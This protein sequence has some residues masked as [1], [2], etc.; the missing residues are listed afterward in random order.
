MNKTIKRVVILLLIFITV[1]LLYFVLNRNPMQQSNPMYRSMEAP[2]LPVVHAQM[3]GREMNV[4]YGYRQEMGNAA[5]RESLT[6]LPQDRALQIRISQSDQPVAALRYEIR[7]L[8]LERL[9]ENTTVSGWQQQ[10]DVVVATLPIQNLLTSDREYLLRIEVDTETYGTAYY[11][12]RIVWTD[13][14]AIQPMID[15]AVDFSRRTFNYEEARELTTYLETNDTEDNSSFGQTTIRSS[16]SH[17]T[18]GRLN[19]EPAGD[20][21]V[22]LKEADGLMGIVQL[23]YLASRQA[24]DGTAELYEVEESFTMRW[25][26]LRIYMMDYQRKADQVFL[27][28]RT[29]YS[30][31]RIMLGITNDQEVSVKKSDNNQMLAF[32]VNRE[33]WRYD[34]TEQ[35]AVQIFSFRSENSAD[36]RSNH[37]DH[38]IN[39]LQVQDNGDVDFLVYG[40]MNRGRHEGDTG[41]AG[42]HYDA[43]D[44]AIVERFFIPVQATYDAIKGDMEQ[45]AGINSSDMLYLYLNQAVYGIDLTSN[46]YMVVA[47][48]LAEGSFAVSADRSRI[49]WQE[50][51]N[52]YDAE[53]LH[54]LDLETGENKIIQAQQ[55]DRVRVIG[56]VGN[57]LVY[58]LAKASDLWVLNGRTVELP[59]YALEIMNTGMGVET[60]YENAGS[61]I[62]DV[63]V[64]ESRIHLTRMVRLDDSQYTA[65]DQDTIV[66]NV[67]MGPDALAGIGWYAS[68]D[69]GK[70]YFVQVDTD[71][72]SNGDVSISA[73]RRISYDS[74]ARLE[75]N[76]RNQV[77]GVQF[78]AYGGG[79]MLG[80]SGDL[81]KVLD[82]AYDSMGV[83]IDQNHNMIWGR[84][85]RGDSR[86]IRDTAVAA[87]PLYRH[88]DEFTGS[89]SYSDGIILIDARGCTMMQVLYFI[90]KG[91]PVVAY[92]GDGSHLLLTGFDQYNVS[93]YDPGTGET[94]RVGLNDATEFFRLRGNDFVCAIS[95]QN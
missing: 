60:R 71:I 88:L 58:G 51:A 26:S 81:K 21:Q 20:V 17:L 67:G 46:E 24:E 38:D 90:D 3:Y 28:D 32:M 2:Q 61:Y 1:V 86:N 27:G 5:A 63:S 25:N 89:E 40:Y 14:A 76:G 47:D 64:E 54:L 18:W 84:I 49:A 22:T 35:D 12:T 9:V 55:E 57:D 10:E 50:G 83:V 41:V 33:L 39:I 82:L 56:F 85:N 91:M 72:R 7:S 34:Q 52:R 4:M 65:T 6:I 75:L 45:L 73:P 16:F 62:A 70:V 8:D 53:N 94:S 69:K 42:Y 59:M 87:A 48:G 44:N 79:H 95:L 78:Y 29:A 36:L 31:K 43:S 19:M 74:S 77:Q 30:G 15:L 13:N 92:T 23:H 11:Y 80:R 37:D 66:C 68:Q 93:V